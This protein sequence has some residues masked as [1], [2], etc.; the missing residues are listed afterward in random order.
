[1]IRKKPPVKRAINTY[2][3]FPLIFWTSCRL[4]D[5]QFLRERG[6]V[7]HKYIPS[8]SAEFPG[9]TI[10]QYVCMQCAQCAD[11]AYDKLVE[12]EEVVKRRA[13]EISKSLA[14]HGKVHL[15]V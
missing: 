12:L 1:M 7:R 13:K 14:K 6:W 4:C 5:N 11:E 2:S 9:Y 10:K 3:T 8:G 15:N